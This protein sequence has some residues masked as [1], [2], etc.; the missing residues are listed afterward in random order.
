MPVEPEQE[1]QYPEETEGSG[2]YPDAPP[3]LETSEEISAV[4]DPTPV[5]PEPTPAAPEPTRPEQTVSPEGA[6]HLD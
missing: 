2:V 1:P 3:I 6:V 4:P 5:V